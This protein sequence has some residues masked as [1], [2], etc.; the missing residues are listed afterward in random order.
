MG[1]SIISLRY[2]WAEILFFLNEA[3]SKNLSV[4]C[5]NELNLKVWYQYLYYKKVKLCR[6]IE[7]FTYASSVY[8]AKKSFLPGHC[9]TALYIQYHSLLRVISGRKQNYS[10]I[11]V[12]ENVLIL[13]RD[14]TRSC[15]GQQ[16]SS[17][18]SDPFQWFSNHSYYTSVK[19]VQIFKSDHLCCNLWY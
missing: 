14:E 5:K 3:V 9:N 16:S 19:I 8:L 13:G 7:R 10:A 15:Q 1:N 18:E 4:P 12:S 11:A 17:R 2:S 6:N